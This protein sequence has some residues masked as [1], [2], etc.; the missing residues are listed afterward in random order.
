[1]NLGGVITDFRER[2]GEI[3]QCKE[4]GRRRAL[5]LTTRGKHLQMTWEEKKELGRIALSE[6]A[7]ERGVWMFAKNKWG[8]RIGFQRG[9][10][11]EDAFF[12]RG[13]E[14]SAENTV[15]LTKKLIRSLRVNGEGEKNGDG[16]G[17]IKFQ[18][19]KADTRKN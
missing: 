13:K 16:G 6:N 10:E 9:Q 12:L 7:K 19:G 14:F 18:R 15:Y 4:E 3:P 17:Q 2:E 8:L 11:R 5:L 1:V